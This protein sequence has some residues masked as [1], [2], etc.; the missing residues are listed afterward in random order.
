L[1][2]EPNTALPREDLVSKPATGAFGQGV[3]LWQY[4]TATDEFG[5]RRSG[6]HFNPGELLQYFCDLSRADRVI[7]QRRI[8]N[9]PAL[10]PLADDALCNIRIVTC[11][12]PSG[13]LEAMPPVIRMGAGRIAA[14][15]LTQGGLAAPIDRATGTICGAALQY[16]DLLGVAFRD[17]HPDSGRSF[18]GFRVPMLEEAIALGLR[19]HRAFASLHFIGWDVAVAPEGPILI[20]GNSIP[21]LDLTVL[22]HGLTLSDT[23]FIPYYNHRWRSRPAKPRP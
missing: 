1:P 10:L 8:R 7:V 11:R 21:D 12:S 15:N 16:H 20:E 18:S 17:R 14:A 2:L 19:A 5:D 4:D 6:Q 22:P 23:Q 9:H 3:R 13:A